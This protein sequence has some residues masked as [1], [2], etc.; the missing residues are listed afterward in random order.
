MKRNSIFLLLSLFFLPL[1]FASGT[2]DLENKALVSEIRISVL[3]GPSGVGLAPLFETSPIIDGAKI[4]MEVSATPDVLLPKLIKGEIDIGILPPN[5][6][7]KVY[8]TS[9]SIILLAVT[10][11]GMLNLLTS[12]E[13][14]KDIHSLVGKKVYVAGQGST[15]D[16][17][18]RYL[19]KNAG[20]KI[21]EKLT[22]NNNDFVELDFSLPT[23]EMAT[24]LAS[25]KISYAFL[26]EPFASIA[27][28]NNPS[29]IRSFDIQDLYRSYSG[30]KTSYPMTVLVARKDFVQNN[31]HSIQKILKEVEA[32]I[33]Y[34]NENPKEAGL[35][36]EKYSL[37]LKA[38]IVTQSIPTSAF[39]F[40][41]AM[42]AKEEIESLL[43]L[44]LELSPESIGGKLPDEG[45]YFKN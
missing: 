38:P 41:Q 29:L 19:A 31:I 37:G 22:A 23:A 26:P 32:A 42:E 45:F 25:G 24:A 7:A 28:M 9:N 12:D 17:M 1:V 2:K 35:L 30:V 13:K 16:Y 14:I 10:G 27:Q 11:K 3:N 20:L 15:P 18:F 40:S 39:T 43:S 21:G 33:H 34:V 44:F 8:N 36:V 6:A 5:A 4:S